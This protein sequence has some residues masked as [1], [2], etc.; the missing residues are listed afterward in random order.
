[1]NK[2]ILSKRI[3]KNLI[4]I[5]LTLTGCGVFIKQPLY[6]K[7]D[8]Q[9][10]EL[11]GNTF[12]YRDG[13]RNSVFQNIF[14]SSDVIVICVPGLGGDAGSYNS[15]Q[16]YF[17]ENKI[18]SVSIDLRGFGHW[19]G[20]AG[21]AENIGL[22]IGDLNQIVD[23]YRTTYSGK[24]VLLLGESLG[25]SLCLWYT[26]FYPSKADG[27]ILTSLVTKKGMN[28][29]KIQTILNLSFGY[30]FSPT[31]PVKL[32]F[33]PAVYSNDPDY[34]KREAESDSPGS[35]KISPRYLIQSDRVVRQSFKYLYT[36]DNPAII[37]SGG[38]DFLS[39][40]NSISKIAGNCKPGKVHFEY[41]PDNHHS[42]VNDLNR[43]KV[44]IKTI[45]ISSLRF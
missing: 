8:N 33:N 1:M 45:K 32:N 26:S 16:Q 23:F 41:F 15:L 10:S 25:S 29:V 38:Q 5:I 11:A 43:N 14:E 22:H 2:R 6:E 30:I 40:Q 34:I 20:E 17:S 36:Y 37:L 28:E 21:D 13:S 4:F 39:D 42:L 19:S 24:K 27:L 31:K 9:K 12:T 3:L 44:F 18:S 7:N 35:K